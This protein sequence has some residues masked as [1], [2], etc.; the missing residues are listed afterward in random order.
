MACWVI[1]NGVPFD[2]A[3]D[4]PDWMLLAYAITFAQAKNGGLEW[5]WDRMTFQEKR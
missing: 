3:H 2:T 5:D 4:M 1:Q